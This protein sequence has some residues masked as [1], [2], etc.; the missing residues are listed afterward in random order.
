MK[1]KRLSRPK[2]LKKINLN[3]NYLLSNRQTNKQTNCEMPTAVQPGF[4]KYGQLPAGTYYIGDLCYILNADEWDYHC[5]Q[6]FTDGYDR[7]IGIFHTRDN[8]PFANISTKYGDGYYWGHFLTN[9][10]DDGTDYCVDSG[11][12]GCFPL[13]DDILYGDEHMF[14]ALIKTRENKAR[15]ETF[16]EPFNVYYNEGPGN[17]VFD[18]IYIYTGDV[19]DQEESDFE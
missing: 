9:E 5:E 17:I 8:I 10:N 19:S 7:K 12:I 13:R 3:Y 1:N 15:I 4:Y 14:K 18:P 16:D 11:T 2:L 6:L